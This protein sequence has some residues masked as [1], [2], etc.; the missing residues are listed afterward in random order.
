MV[1]LWAR[2]LSSNIADMTNSATFRDLLHY[3]NLRHDRRLYFTSEGRHF[4]DF[5]AFKNPTG[6]AGYE[7]ENFGTKCHLATPSQQKLQNNPYDI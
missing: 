7:P 4:E 5:F 2:M 6:S 1:E 3:A